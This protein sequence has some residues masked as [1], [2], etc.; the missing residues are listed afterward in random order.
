MSLAC[1]CVGVGLAQTIFKNFK[2]TVNILKRYFIIFNEAH[3]PDEIVRYQAQ[4]S[5]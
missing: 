1:Q 3:I 4:R 5:S 2:N